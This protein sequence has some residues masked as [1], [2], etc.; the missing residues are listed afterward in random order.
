MTFDFDTSKSLLCSVENR[1]DYS[2]HL[3]Q[4]LRRRQNARMWVVGNNG[5][6]SKNNDVSWGRQEVPKEAILSHSVHGPAP[7]K[8]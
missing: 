5:R 7:K 6:L 3:A 4:S 2:T 8:T 1:G